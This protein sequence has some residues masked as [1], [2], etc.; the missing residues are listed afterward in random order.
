MSKALL[1]FLL[2]PILIA[3]QPKFPVTNIVVLRNGNPIS[4][5][6]AGGFNNPIFSE[7][8][9]NGDSLK[10]L[11]VYDKAG[12]K[13]MVF[14]NTG[15][16][17]HPSFTYAPQ[18]ER[19]FP[20]TLRDWAIMRDYNH[21]GVSD[22]FGN[23]IGAAI[24]VWKGSWLAD[25]YLDYTQAYKN[26]TYHVND[27]VNPSIWTFAD[28]MPVIM[29]INGD[30]N[31]DILAPDINGGLSLDYYQNQSAN[32]GFPSDSLYFTLGNTCQDQAWGG[33]FEDILDC[34]VTLGNCK[35][36]LPIP[37]PSPATARHQGGACCGFHYRNDKVVS[38]LLADILCPTTKF[39]ENGGDTSNASIVAYDTIFPH[40]DVPVYCPIAPCAY[41]IDGNNDG[42]EDL[43]FAPFARDASQ[44]G[45]SQDVNVVLYYQNIGVD[46]VNLFHYVSDTMIIGG[47]DIGTESHAVFFD[48]NNDS[49]MDIV[50][51][52]YGQFSQT[53]FPTSYLALYQNIGTRT[54]PKYQETS[55]DWSG[56][57][58]YQ[59]NGLY[60]A[61]GDLD[62]DG[63]P[64][65]LVGDSYGNVSFFHNAGT[66]IASYPSMTDPDWFGINVGANA[67]PF[68]YDVN[69]D[70]LNDIVIGSKAN[71]I[72]YYWN[73][74][75]S[76]N[77]MFSQDS[78]NV[79]F[80][81]IKVYDHTVAGPPPGYATP[82]ITIENG[83]TVIYTGSQVGRI[84]KYAVDPNKL[85]SGTFTLIDSDVL[86]T[87]PGL[88]STVSVSDINGDG[89]NDYLTGNIRGGLNLYSDANW[90]NVPVISSITEPT[91]NKSIMQVY[92]NPAHDKVICRLVNNGVTLTSAMLY[93]LLGEAISVPVNK[94][95]DDA[96]VLSIAGISDGIYVVQAQDSRGEMYQCK[97][98]IYK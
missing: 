72:L 92:P 51:G 52:N 23:N 24:S 12:W 71:N 17:G 19:M 95:G 49:L 85:R 91:V 40:Y 13:A 10:D 83:Q 31:L 90:G 39:L 53:G 86:G 29:D 54:A 38:L 59:L 96:I 64:D 84:F 69:G 67:A 98:S 44:E 8:N 58:A 56:L 48:Y 75:T 43:V 6:W 89:M 28:N 88:R 33:F 65:M 80:G 68:I 4:N 81:N 82:F 62:G 55:L 35:K 73:F 45:Q 76:T 66:T 14:L 94:Q 50:V 87:K 11:F 97:I 37:T 78:V 18:Y 3:A 63:N 26:L 34:G 30:E 16:A 93:D 79:S 15:S 60:P 47:I 57:R 77:P 74:G 1:V 41:T 7:I 22:I 2:V 25:G 21:D 36:G 20:T 46:S 61:F 5:A 9:I 70:G 27:S 32:M 42:Y